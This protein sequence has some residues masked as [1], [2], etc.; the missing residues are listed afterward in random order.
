M[1]MLCHGSVAAEFPLRRHDVHCESWLLE[2]AR[3]ARGV[4]VVKSAT[5]FVATTSCG[6]AQENLWAGCINLSSSNASRRSAGRLL[7]ERDL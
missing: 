3:C 2:L 6:L 7:T 1:E 4:I 5:G